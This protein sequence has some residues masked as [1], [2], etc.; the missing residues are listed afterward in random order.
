[1]LAAL[2]PTAIN[3]LTKILGEGRKKRRVKR[4][5]IKRANNDEKSHIQKSNLT[6]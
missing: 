4:V 1:M 3:G 5:A 2:A 6:K